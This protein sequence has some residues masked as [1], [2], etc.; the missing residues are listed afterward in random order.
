[1]KLTIGCAERIFLKIPLISAE[2]ITSIKIV[3][4]Q[5]KY[6]YLV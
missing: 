6:P 5:K 1:L 4:R 2:M 3:R